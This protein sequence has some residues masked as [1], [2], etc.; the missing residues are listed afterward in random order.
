[1]AGHGRT[2][3]SGRAVWG[4]ACFAV[5]A[6]SWVTAQQP[7]RTSV[8]VVQVPVVVR[9][10]KGDLVHGLKASDF[11]VREDGRLQR[12]AFFSEG[13]PGERLPLHLGVMLDTSESMA[14]DL[15]EAANAAVRFVHALDEPV[16][17]TFVGFD[18]DVRLSVFSPPDYPQLF[19]RIR[20]QHAAGMTAFYDAIGVYLAQAERRDGQQVLVAYTDGSD[21]TSSLTFSELLK[22]LRMDDRVIVYVIGYL[23]NEGTA[24]FALQSQLIEIARTTG[25]NA[26]FP[27]S[28]HQVG[29]VY[30]QI[31]DELTS[32]YTLGYLPASPTAG[33]GGFRKIE[34][35]VVRR[36]L[37]GAKVQTRAGYDAARPNR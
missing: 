21:S 4:A 6:G 16:D 37:E 31:V 33:G 15:G 9:G 17:V 19:A 24:R 10:A 20:G 23:D 25:G 18:S 14:A 30:R 32:R 5:A 28:L 35:R 13:A 22:L 12:I 34:V 8:D 26:F 3:T 7:F 2:L 27:V 1:M 11:E 29:D 36:G